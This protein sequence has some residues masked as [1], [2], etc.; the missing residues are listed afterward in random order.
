M[1]GTTKSW[2]RAPMRAMARRPRSSSPPATT[3]PRRAGVPKRRAWRSGRAMRAPRP[4]QRR[5]S[6]KPASSS[7][8]R[9]PNN[10]FP[11]CRSRVQGSAISARSLATPSRNM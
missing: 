4:R 10:W 11:R 2:S 9:K 5:S 8:T 6:A 7:F 3:S 1:T